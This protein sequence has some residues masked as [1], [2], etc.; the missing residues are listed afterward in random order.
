MENPRDL[1]GT[2]N[3]AM[4]AFWLVISDLLLGGALPA[5][6]PPAN[7]AGA[8]LQ[9]SMNRRLIGRGWSSSAGNI[10]WFSSHPS[11][12]CAET[13]SNIFGYIL[14]PSNVML[15]MELKIDK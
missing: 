13:E 5:A 14:I 6:L 1:C 4:A 7:I 3:C 9:V 12:S 11:K 15:Q 10:C 8:S 2:L